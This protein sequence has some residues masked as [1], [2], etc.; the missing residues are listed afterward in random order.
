MALELLTP[1]IHTGEAL[2]DW[3]NQHHKLMEWYLDTSSCTL[4]HNAEGVWTKHYATDI[5]RLQFQVDAHSCDVP[6]QYTHI[7]D[8]CECASY[9]EIVGKHTIIETLTIKTTYPISYTSGIG[10]SCRTLPHH[11]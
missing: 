3:R 1:D 2:G 8:V 6:N 5:G 11:V 7:V 4:Y 9:M 10:D